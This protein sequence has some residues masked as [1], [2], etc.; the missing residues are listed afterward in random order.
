MTLGMV[1]LE[2]FSKEI[3][4]EVN[5]E[6][7]TVSA[8]PKVLGRPHFQNFKE[9]FLSVRTD[10]GLDPTGNATSSYDVN[11]C[12]NCSVY[13]KVPTVKEHLAYIRIK[14]S[15][16]RFGSTIFFFF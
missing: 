14:S 1:Y 12:A 8:R 11:H 5:K 4:S 13:M 15:N 3:F 16:R 10:V 9:K 7:E 2:G 6:G